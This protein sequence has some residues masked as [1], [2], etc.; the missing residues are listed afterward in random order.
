M[1]G[2]VYR[3]KTSLI[4]SPLGVKTLGIKILSDGR[5]VMTISSVA[6]HWF[7]S[8]TSTVYVVVSS[9][10]TVMIGQ[11]V[12]TEAPNQLYW[13]IAVE[14]IASSITESPG[15]TCW[16]AP[17]STSTSGGLIKV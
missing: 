7:A 6:T 1:L 13:L 14:E 11:V 15:D 17:R 9:G 2:P 10:N 16:S 3:E 12:Q 8:I 4:P 5:I